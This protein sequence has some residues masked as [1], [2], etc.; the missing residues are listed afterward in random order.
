MIYP[1]QKL[2]INEEKLKRLKT[3]EIAKNVKIEPG[4]HLVGPVKINSGTVLKSGTYIEGPVEIGKNCRLG[5]NCHLRAFAAIGDDVKIG[6][7]VEIKNSIIGYNANVAH[8]SYVGDSVIG[9]F[10]NL[11]AGTITANL[12]HDG[13]TIRV[14]WGSKIIDTETV[15]F[16]TYIGD[17][18]KTA[19]H[20]SIYP[21]VII[22]P[23]V[24]TLPNQIIDKNI[25]CF[26]LGSKK[27]TKEKMNTYWTKI[28]QE[29]LKFFEVI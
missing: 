3:S 21:G 9:N 20:T 25:A 24:L 12:R 26:T 5:P 7:A 1:W 15:K 29:L 8:L 16:G 17:Y 6:Q 27:I 2:I 23:Y 28:D 19:I 22:A 10:V 13:K 18:S 4:V 14:K 11:G